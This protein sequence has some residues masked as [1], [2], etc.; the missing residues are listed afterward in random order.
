M[1]A[2]IKSTGKIIE[3]EPVYPINS[4]KCVYFIEA[5]GTMWET[6][7]IELLEHFRKER[8]A[9]ATAALQ[10]ILA[11]DRLVNLVDRYNG[12]IEKGVVK[13]AVSITDKLLDEIDKSSAKPLC[14]AKKGGNDAD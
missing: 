13:L 5:N 8:L 6:D 1:K 10:G 12:G 4:N 11:N 3:V 7:S 2:K 14:P 9:V